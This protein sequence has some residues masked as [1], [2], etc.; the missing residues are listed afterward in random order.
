MISKKGYEDVVFVL[1]GKGEQLKHVRN[2]TRCC[3]NVVLPGW[4]DSGE[5]GE[6]LKR[7]YLGLVP[8]KSIENTIP[9]K[10]FEYLSAGVPM[11]SSLEGEMAD[12]IRKHGLGF[13][14]RSGDV[15][16]LCDCIERVLD[17]SVLRE[18]ISANGLK[19]FRKYGDADKIYT[20]YAEH[21]EQLV[22][23]HRRGSRV[24]N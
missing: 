18:E 17:N 20:D 19:F 13:N 15:E 6:V 24:Q 8:C 3:R 12:L 11:V 21:I 22:E 9:N 7:A 14:Y 23:T 16:G 1:A 4:I 5:I 2:E 10:S